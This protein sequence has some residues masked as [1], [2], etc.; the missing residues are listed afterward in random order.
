MAFLFP[1]FLW[2]L[3]A[4]AVPV[5][6]HL[7]QLRRFKR[8]EFSSVRFLQEVSQQ[9]RSRKKVRH[10]L[11]LLSRLLALTCLVFAFAQPYLPGAGSRVKAGQRAVSLF[12][13]DSW[14]MDGTNAEGRL[15]DQARKDAQDAV[16]AF[17][18]TD[19]FQVITNKFEGRQQLLLGRDEALE[20]AGKAEVGP[21]SEIINFK[22]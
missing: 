8:M 3:A 7:F 4:L 10:W 19:R 1:S 6:I 17:N 21:F 11:V 9:T 12:I 22:K 15:L 16:M 18:A 2:A 14:S 5:I 20:S 13:D